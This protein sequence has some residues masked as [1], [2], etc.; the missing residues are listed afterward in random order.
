MKTQFLIICGF[1]M[2]VMIQLATRMPRTGEFATAAVASEESRACITCHAGVKPNLVLAWERSRHAR[3]GVGCY[4]CHARE[5]GGPGVIDNHY[6][7]SIS[8]I[9]TPTTCNECHE[10]QVKSF[11]ASSHSRSARH[12]TGTPEQ[13]GYEGA[14][15]ERFIGGV[16]GGVAAMNAG[17]KACHGTVI[18]FD[19]K[20]GRPT[21]DTF[22]NYGMGRVNPDGTSGNC[23]ACHSKHDFRM[24]TVRSAEVC[25]RCHRGHYHPQYE[26]WSESKHG[27]IYKT[28]NAHLD[29]S[30]RPLTLGK[31]SII[32]P[33]CVTCHLGD[34]T[35]RHVKQTHDPGERIS[36]RN[37]REVSNLTDNWQDKRERMQKV[38]HLCHAV[39][40]T[41]NHYERYDKAVELYNKKFGRPGLEIIR[42]LFEDG[43]IG[44]S[45][46]GEAVERSWYHIWRRHGRAARMGAAM[47]GSH[48]Q[49]LGF[50]ETARKFYFEFLPA[51][52]K[53]SPGI[54]EKILK[55]EEHAWL[56]D[57]GLTTEKLDR[58]LADQQSFHNSLPP[59]PMVIPDF[60]WR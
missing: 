39:S 35:N 34:T 56:F 21:A 44:H 23:I 6:G 28:S 8:N 13:T 7:F 19:P 33:T 54:T 11:L 37:T 1:L 53:L 49:W 42:A 20:T 22:P 12:V 5:P 55:G 47:M 9:V 38:C 16:M 24:D 57:G 15:L 32:A 25:G 4:D 48:V 36:R 45:P 60:Q 52:E 18:A 41:R 27:A 3:E 51:A 31:D 46:F 10:P 30:K 50:F 26:I 40:F 58:W 59:V 2:V 43:L 14:L 17:C 29:L